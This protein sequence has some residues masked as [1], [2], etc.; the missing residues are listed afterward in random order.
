MGITNSN[1]TVDVHQ[2]SCD[3][4]VKVTL[5]LAAAPN[6]HNNPLD[7]VLVLDRSESMEGS[8]LENLKLGA[9]KFIDIIAE[10]TNSCCD[11][12]I[13]DGNRIGIVSFADTAMANTQL[14]TSVVNLK[15]AVNCLAAD[16]D[17]NHGAAFTKAM[18]LLTNSSEN[19]KVMV[20]FTDGETTAGLPPA[21]IAATAR[22]AGITIYVIG[23]SGKK[24]IDVTAINDWATDPDSSHVAITP[25]ASKLEK[26]FEDLAKNICRPG[27]TGIVIK[28]MV[29]PDFKIVNILAPTKGSAMLIKENCLRWNINQ[30]GVHGCEG[31]SLEFYIQHIGNISGEKKVNKSITYSDNENNVVIF[32]DPTVYVDCGMAVCVEGCQEPVSVEI[33]GCTDFVEYDLGDSFLASLGRILQLDVNLRN[34]CPGRRVALAVLLTEVDEEGDEHQRG[35]KTVTIPA[36]HF[37]TC[38]DI[39]V[40]CIRF[41]LPEDLD[42]DDDPKPM[43]RK[44]TFKARVF[45]NYIDT[46]FYCSG[47][48]EVS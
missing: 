14:I 20:V 12:M 31:A 48:I 19:E 24:G 37:S 6:I 40:K 18:E 45:N 46:D 42:T 26:I 17:T 13:R 43:C 41:V 21:P 27:A 10:A 5:C 30:L 36:H 35:I 15:S 44:R 4:M 2:I 16:G 8:A 32:P 34:I 28:E 33:D 1:K 29:E 7:I 11:G 3:G 47:E 38:K 39:K 9:N 25:D 22:A 23:L